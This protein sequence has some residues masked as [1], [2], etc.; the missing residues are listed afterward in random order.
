MRPAAAAPGD[1]S[2]PPAGPASET[3][4]PRNAPPGRPRAFRTR[5]PLEQAGLAVRRNGLLFLAAGFS[6][7]HAAGVWLP[8]PPRLALAGLAVLVLATVVAGGWRLRRLSRGER[9]SLRHEVGL[10]LLLVACAYAAIQLSGEQHSPLQPLAYLLAA[11]FAVAP[12]PRVAAAALVAA[13][14]GQHALRLAV[15]ERLPTE[16]PALVIQAGF[17]V[18]FALLYQLLLGARLA[19]SRKAE[20]EAV[21]RRL[22]EA[23]EQARALRLLSVDR[24]ADPRSVEDEAA[25]DRRLLLGSLLELERAVGSLVE[26][27][28]LALSSHAVALY[29]LDPDETSLRLRDGRCPAG[30]LAAGPLP[31]GGGLPGAVLRQGK[32]VRVTAKVS[33]V[34]WYERRVDVRAAVAVPVIERT[35]DGT[36]YVRGVLL[37]DRLEPEPFSER[38]QQFLEELAAQVA[39]ASEAE[40]LVR[41]LHHAKAARDRL[42]RAAD[43]LNRLAT[44]D[45]VARAAARLARELATGLDLSAVTRVEEGAAGATHVVLA[46]EGPWA[47]RCEGLEFLD[48]DGLVAQVARLGAVLPARAP[49][50][51]DRPRVFEERLACGSLRVFPLS[52]G[53]RVLGTL[54][55]AADARGVLDRPAEEALHGLASLLAGALARARAL[56]ELAALATTDPLTGLANRRQLESVGRRAVREARRYGRPLAVV[57]GDV[58]HFKRVNDTYGHPAGDRVLQAV[59]GALRAEARGTDLVARLG[60]EEFVLLLPQTDADGALGL[61]ERIRRRLEAAVIDGGPGAGQLRVTLSL[62]VASLPVHGAELDALIA[63]ADE[64]LYAAKEGGRNRALVSGRDAAA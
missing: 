54:V 53:E 46:A 44:W 58:D 1:P 21:E 6:L 19:A 7:A 3:R 56:E 47:E 57:V 45:E 8:P 64:A 11:L 5:T 29:W 20:R 24:S 38:E 42:R 2:P 31:A 15:L 10:G 12:L 48:N 36:G 22:R 62:G 18:T 49:G 16:W 33:G 13:T 35:L 28:S 43:E 51:L 27:A 40:R 14:V 59:A 41:E 34:T 63:A 4:R 25:R 39:R 23:E 60:G 30:L 37:A 17:T 9:V 55:A 26:G 32:P 52:A 61:A 50:T